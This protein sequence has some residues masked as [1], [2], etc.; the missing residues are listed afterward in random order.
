MAGS[1][2]MK[3]GVLL[4]PSE[5]GVSQHERAVHQVLG[6][7]IAALLPKALPEQGWA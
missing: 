7:K 2:S 5:S 4:L 3:D 1:L 6:R